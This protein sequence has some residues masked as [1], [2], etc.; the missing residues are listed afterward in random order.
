M[1]PPTPPSPFAATPPFPP[2]AQVRSGP[3]RPQDIVPALVACA[4]FFLLVSGLP[5]RAPAPFGSGS[6][7]S[8]TKRVGG[9]RGPVRY[10]AGSEFLVT[11]LAR[12]LAF[13]FPVQATTAAP[14]VFYSSVAVP[15]QT[16]VAGSKPVARR[17]IVL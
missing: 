3:A 6:A 2:S 16:L 17:R 8:A 5:R 15:G 4:C 9:R 11:E 14:A 1:S 12:A 10:P 13:Q 7:N